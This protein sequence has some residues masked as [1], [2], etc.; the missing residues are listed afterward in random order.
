MDKR[1]KK[2]NKAIKHFKEKRVKD[3]YVGKELNDCCDIEQVI[4]WALFPRGDR[5]KHEHQQ[6]VDTIKYE[7]LEKYLFEN[8][9]LFKLAKN[10][11]EVF[12][13][14]KQAEIFVDR[15]C[16]TNYDIA[17]RISYHLGFYPERIYLH[18]GVNTGIKALGLK[19]NMKSI[20][21][22]EF[23]K[24][25]GFTPDLEAYQIE[26]FLCIYKD[27]FKRL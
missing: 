14:V 22:E 5:K 4:D 2:I 11:E 3:I 7:K 21:K 9:S 6:R 23:S 25:I 8:K 13:I 17:D 19:K 10:F 12:D 15:D 24:L 27:F 1:E 20:T 26:D 18:R 16:L